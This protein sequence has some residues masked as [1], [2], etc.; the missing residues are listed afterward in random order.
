MIQTA[1]GKHV[2]TMSSDKPDLNGSPPKP[3]PSE[4]FG[5]SSEI[6]YVNPESGL[7][8]HVWDPNPRLPGG[9]RWKKL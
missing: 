9:G 6:Y 1:D 3:R 4:T 2:V 8:T 5:D 7:I